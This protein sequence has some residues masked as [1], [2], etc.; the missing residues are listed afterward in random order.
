MTEILKY[1]SNHVT[2]I[3]NIIAVICTLA[4]FSILY[5]ENPYYRLFEHIFIGLACGQGVFITWTDMI[6]P[7]WWDVLFV[8]GQW[9]WAFALPAGLMFYYVFSKKNSWISKLMFGFL[10]G[11]GAGMAFQ[12]FANMTIPQIRGSFKPVIPTPGVPATVA[13]N[14]FIFVFIL[15]TIMSYFFFSIDHKTKTMRGSAKLGRWFL[16]FAFGAMFGSTV[17][18]RMALFIGRLD[19]LIGWGTKISWL[20]WGIMI[21]IIALILIGYFLFRPQPP[22]KMKGDYE[23]EPAGELP[24]ET[25]EA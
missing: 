22:K 19:F 9:W 2:S 20:G 4:I 14:N 15:I 23:K 16:M 12:D 21:G 18:A 5:K 11:L 7:K 25:T 10:M 17:M 13:V 3:S 1:I 24:A 6:K 8:Q